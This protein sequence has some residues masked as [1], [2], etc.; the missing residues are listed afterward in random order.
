MEEA[1]ELVNYL[2]YSYRDKREQEY[3][4]FVW[5]A[6]EFNYLNEKY[7]FANLAFHLLYMSY[8]SFSVWQIRSMRRL[9]FEKAMVGFQSGVE[10][11][12]L[13]AITPFEFYEHLK[14]ANI[15]RFLKLI[16][17]SNEHV[18]EFSKF[19][20]RRNKIAHPSGDIFFNDKAS[21]DDHVYEVIKEVNNIQG[22]MR[23]IIE[24]IY[25]HFLLD[26]HDREAWQYS[27]ASDQITGMLIH[28][29]YLSNKDIETC[30]DYD[31]R[32]LTSHKH[33]ET[34]KE[35]HDSLIAEYKED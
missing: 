23:P 8:V 22:H 26:N 16:G 31:I 4:S 1:V 25:Y 15:F 35:L 30:L 28:N 13:S 11:K 18:G 10:N 33:Y 27:L 5:E 14:E 19:V 2:P 29:N 9:D 24:E 34:I 21:M 12:I 3:I 20:K 17:C 32:Q 7:E 6:F